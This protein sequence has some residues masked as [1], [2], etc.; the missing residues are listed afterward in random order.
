MII[1]ITYD[2]K[3]P[4]R[5]YAKLYDTIKS[6]PAWWHHLESTWIIFTQE[7]VTKWREKIKAVLDDNDR[8]LV[9]NITKQ[10]RDG[11]LDKTAWAWLKEREVQ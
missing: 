2:L 6:A 3:V 8:L 11:W 9:V 7:S 10:E 1:L 4:G 5:D